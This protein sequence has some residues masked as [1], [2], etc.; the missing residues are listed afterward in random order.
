M[1]GWHRKNETFQKRADTLQ[2]PDSAI[3]TLIPNSSHSTHHLT[4][5]LAHNP[6]HTLLR[7]LH[8]IIPNSL[9][10]TRWRRLARSSS[11]RWRC[12]RLRRRFRRFRRF[13]RR[14]HKALLLVWE[15]R[16]GR[17]VH[18]S[19]SRLAVR[20]HVIVCNISTL[21]VFE[22]HVRW[23]RSGHDNVPG[24]EKAGEEAEAC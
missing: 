11:L 9:L 24:M 1:V 3:H 20:L 5:T 10:V 7:M 15:L 19:I 16:V 13:R 23:V 4:T 14:L 18:C 17:A 21:G 6:C 22:L 8:L 2:Q 12:G